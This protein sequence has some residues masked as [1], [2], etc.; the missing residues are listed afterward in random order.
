RPARR[1]PWPRF[2]GRLM[3]VEVSADLV[4]IFLEDAREHLAF[5]DDALLRMEREGPR[6]EIAA[7]VLGPLHTLQGHNGMIGLA[8]V[9]DYIH[10]LEDVFARVKDAS[11]ALPPSA[12]DRLF[13]GARGLRGAVGGAAPSRAP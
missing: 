7:S 6:P 3:E 4:G 10:R 13:A 5:L 2:L 9:K 12:L 11:L 8:A 1:E